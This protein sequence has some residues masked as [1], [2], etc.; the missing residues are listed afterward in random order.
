VAATREAIL[1]AAA[2]VFLGNGCAGAGLDE[3]AAR[4]GV[5]KQ[6]VHKHFPS[7]ERLF[8]DLVLR[9][10]G[11]VD[12]LVH[13]AAEALPD[14]ADLRADLTA[15]ARRFVGHLLQPDVMRLR[16][17]VI[18]EADRFPAIGRTFYAEGPERVS[19]GLARAFV[20][21]SERGRLRLGD[22]PDAAQLAAYHY[23]W[24]VLSMPWNRVLLAG[25]AERPGDDE[26]DRVV[27]AGVTAF[28]G[29]YAVS[30]REESMDR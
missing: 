4:A 8:S 7:K 2:E 14:S 11:E 16:R 17:L 23:C 1:D 26:I 18:A 15:L 24:L 30:R 12:R 9:S 20:A 5:S 22:G 3:V 13:E 28:L 19:L 27:D 10:V 29:A 25:S 6:T 21:L